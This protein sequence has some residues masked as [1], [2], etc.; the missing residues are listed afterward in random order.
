MRYILLVI[1]A[2]AGSSIAWT[3]SERSLIREG[4]RLYKD[5]KYADAE[6]DYRKALEKNKNLQQGTFNLGDALYKQGRFAEAAEQYHAAV[7][8]A[9]DPAL[10]AQAYHNLGNAL[11]KAQKLP[12]SIS[13][14]KEALK[15]NPHDVD[16]KYN[17]EYAKALLKQQQSR[18]DK[19]QKNDDKQQQDKQQQQNQDKKNEQ[20]QNQEQ[21][22]QDQNKQS[23]EQ[24]SRQQQAQND[25][26]KQQDKQK[27]TQMKKI[28][29]SKE[30]A[31]RI[32]EALKN[33]EKA[34]QKKLHK[35]APARVK[36][37]K[38]W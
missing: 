19:N 3:Q 14:Y 24:Q 4:N 25:D 26:K 30:D 36:V 1:I 23:Q 5:N 12:E 29:I 28:Q 9:S 21:Q 34:V 17:L 13:A 6:V 10:K 2:L 7:S 20:K 11:L 33:E 38:D 22:N 15:A 27:G 18:K 37:E 8:G 31:E 16:T 35:K 32:L